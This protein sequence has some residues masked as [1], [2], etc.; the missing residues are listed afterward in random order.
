MASQPSPI[1]PLHIHARTRPPGPSSGDPLWCAH[2]PPGVCS[3][4]PANLLE[5][6]PLQ[7]PATPGFM[8]AQYIWGALPKLSF[9]ADPVVEAL[10]SVPL[11]KLLGWDLIERRNA[12]RPDGH[13]SV[14]LVP[15]FCFWVGTIHYRGFQVTKSAHCPAAR[16]PSRMAQVRSALWGH[17][18]YPSAL[19]SKVS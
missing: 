15:F 6:R 10:D 12:T 9:S 2:V 7:R 1:S 4:S 14:S 8:A 13:Q 11:H 17:P 3:P 16:P 5:N 19:Q 18:R